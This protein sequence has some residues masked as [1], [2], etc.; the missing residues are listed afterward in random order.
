MNLETYRKLFKQTNHRNSTERREGGGETR[1]GALLRRAL[2]A[3]LEEQSGAR[4]QAAGCSLHGSLL[5][6]GQCGGILPPPGQTGAAGALPKKKATRYTLKIHSWFESPH[7]RHPKA[8]Q[9][10]ATTDPKSTIVRTC[11]LQQV[12]NCI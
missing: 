3:S 2:G 12:C 4:P 9:L 11:E 7:T 5:G 6:P 8:K 10:C 1:S